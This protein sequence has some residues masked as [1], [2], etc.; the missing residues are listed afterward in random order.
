MISGIL[1]D[2]DGTLINTRELYREVYRYVVQPYVRKPLTTE[3]IRGSKPTPERE[4]IR[5]CVPEKEREQAFRR[6]LRHYSNFHDSHFGGTY[7]GVQ[8]MLDNLRKLN[9]PIGIVTGKSR[10]AWKITSEK[11]ALGHFDVIITDDDVDQNKPNLEGLQMALN[12]LKLENTN[13]LY[14]GD[15]LSDFRIA[16]DAGVNFAATLWSK[17]AGEQ[18]EFKKELEGEKDIWF[19]SQPT[20]LIQHLKR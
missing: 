10:E 14:A 1:F 4:F 20:E 5:R 12:K 17:T 2:L 3:D 18:A 15:H 19:L 9:Y 11:C 16:R 13:T 6:F 7:E 8:E